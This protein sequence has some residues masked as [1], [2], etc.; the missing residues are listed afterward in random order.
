[1]ALLN[2]K[3]EIGPLRLLIVQPTPFCNINCDYCYLAGRSTNGV[4]SVETFGQLLSIVFNSD[5]VED[6]FRLVW[7]GG[8]P[9]A[10]GVTVL[11][12][13][14]RMLTEANTAH[15]VVG[16]GLQTNATLIDDRWI[17]FFTE[18]DIDV[19]VSIDGPA[20]LHDIHR[21]TR[22]GKGT[23]DAT[24]RGVERLRRADIPFHVIA[25]VTRDTLAQAHELMPFFESLGA[26][27]IGFNFEEKEGAHTSSTLAHAELDRDLDR[28]WQDVLQSS[29]LLARPLPVREID[30]SLARIGAGGGILDDQRVPLR[31]VTCDWRG[32]LSTFSPELIEA[33]SPEFDDFIFG[34]VTALT[35]L[36]DVANN[37]KIHFAAGQIAEGVERCRNTC[38]YFSACGGGV[39][40]NKYFEHGDLGATQ[41]LFC[42]SCIQAPLRFALDS[43][44][45]VGDP[46]DVYQ[47]ALQHG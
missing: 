47:R 4:M 22:S 21:R 27:R 18:H 9:L 16:V 20:A 29:A 39:P 40:G 15:V 3:P 38:E 7:H 23:F 28:F 34:N 12:S 42:R 35:R 14:M 33:K 32:N 11:D 41:T 5:L 45:R 17:R 46:R 2:R 25:V 44:P 36:E 10:A 30:E 24:L 31:I 37:S 43:A 1:M 8:E 6:G 26:T 13:Y 19:G